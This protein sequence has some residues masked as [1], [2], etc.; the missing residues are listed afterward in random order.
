MSNSEELRYAYVPC[1]VTRIFFRAL[2]ALR[3][4]LGIEDTPA[5]SPAGQDTGH[6]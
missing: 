6:R 5:G 1:K 3:K 2:G 4:T